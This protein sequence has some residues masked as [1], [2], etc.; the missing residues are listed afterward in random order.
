MALACVSLLIPSAWFTFVASVNNL[1]YN[2][3]DE[4]SP[5]NWL[6]LQSQAD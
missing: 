5:G 2:L 1:L 3:P 4:A 6:D